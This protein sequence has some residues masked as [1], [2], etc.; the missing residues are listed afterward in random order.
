MGELLQATGGT[1]APEK[2]YWYLVEVIRAKGK[3]GYVRESQAPQ[4][5]TLKDGTMYNKRLEV[6]QAKQALGIMIRPDAKMHDEAQM[7][8]QLA[9]K[10]CDGV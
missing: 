2:S 3:W 5:L 9:H 4:K 7:L 6:Y 8:E 1:L 10:W